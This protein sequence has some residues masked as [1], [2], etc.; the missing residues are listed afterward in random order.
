M[1][2]ELEKYNELSK[3]PKDIEK[4]KEE[5]W[6]SYQE[7]LKEMTADEMLEFLQKEKE[8]WEAVATQEKYRFSERNE[9]TGED[10][11]GQKGTTGEKTYHI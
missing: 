2:K 6:S 7:H 11:V 1:E 3:V 9:T 8:F 10:T 5:H 4:K